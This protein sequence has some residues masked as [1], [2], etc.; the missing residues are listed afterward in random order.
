M[1]ET[2]RAVRRIYLTDHPLIKEMLVRK[3]QLRVRMNSP[4]YE[5]RTGRDEILQLMYIPA[6]QIEDGIL[7]NTIFYTGL[8]RCEKDPMVMIYNGFEETRSG[9][10]RFGLFAELTG[11]DLKRVSRIR[12]EYLNIYSPRPEVIPSSDVVEEEIAV[13]KMKQWAKRRIDERLQEAFDEMGIQ[14]K[15]DYE[16]LPLYRKIFRIQRDIL[17]CV[18]YQATEDG[19]YDYLHLLEDVAEETNL[20]ILSAE[21][22]LEELFKEGVITWP[23]AAGKD[24]L[25]TDPELAEEAGGS[26]RSN[27]TI[28][29][30]LNT[31]TKRERP[32]E[33]KSGIAVM[34]RFLKLS[35]AGNPEEILHLLRRLNQDPGRSILFREGN[36]YRIDETEY[37]KMEKLTEKL[38][39]FSITYTLQSLLEAFTSGDISRRMFISEIDEMEILP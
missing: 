24:I 3:M 32:M 10:I 33:I 6:E 7:Q 1:A 31:E 22:V 20:D 34:I 11:L 38:F 29:D 9:D 35:G 30:L 36:Q 4:Y 26:C 27:Q 17:P 14:T 37:E 5:N 12:T 25:I 21:E 16:L 28:L 2:K 39:D 23:Y 19:P 13:L 8:L 18:S 15:A